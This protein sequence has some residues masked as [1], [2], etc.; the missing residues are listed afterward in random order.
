MTNKINREQAEAWRARYEDGSALDDISAIESY[1]AGKLISP[2]RVR[3]A[4]VWVGGRI[5][6]YSETVNL[7]LKKKYAR[8]EL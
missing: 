6:T 4:I 1:R 5:R 7:K 2:H 3:E 8:D